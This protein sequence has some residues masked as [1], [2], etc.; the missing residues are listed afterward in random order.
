VLTITD[1][2]VER[3]VKGAVNFLIRD[4]RV[5]FEIDLDLA[6]A[7]HLLVSSK[8]VGV[9]ARVVPQP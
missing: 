2:A 5:R 3:S 1:G 8:L 7:H 6:A 9:A 4:N